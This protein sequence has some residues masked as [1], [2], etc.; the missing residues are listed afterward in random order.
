MTSS[1]RVRR[2][3][4]E[5]VGEFTRI[6]N[7][8][9]GISSAERA[10]DVGFMREW[11]SQPSC[12]PEENCYLLDV[13][14]QPVG[15]ALIAPELPIGRTVASGGVLESHRRQGYGRRLLRT[16]AQHARELGAAVLHAQ[17]HEKGGSAQH[18]LESEGFV[19]VRTYWHMRWEAGQPPIVELPQGFSVDRFR[20][21]KDEGAL[22]EL[23]NAA[24]DGSWGFCPNTVEEIAA[25]VRL[26]RVDPGGII[27]V[28]D[29]S[30]PAA[31]NWTLRVANERGATGWIAMTGVHPDYRGKRLGT[32]VV[33]AGIEDLV[34]KGVESV[35]LEVDSQNQAA[36]ELYLKLGFEK[37]RESWWYELRLT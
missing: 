8:V 37:Q 9:N 35:E 21:D 25:R 5:D 15:F 11:L 1:G 34:A 18:L 30:R 14:G 23:Q 13:E 6:F 4:W 26:S 32:A 3:R 19:L 22:T 2:F 17:V 27:T 31:Y 28:V 29:G 7:E 20:R 33:A 36:R 12:R 16:A 10:F 24:F